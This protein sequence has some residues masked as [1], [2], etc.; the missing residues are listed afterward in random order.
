MNSGP[1]DLLLADDDNDDCRFF[2]EAVEELSLPTHLTMVHDGEQLMKVLT[3]KRAT[4]PH[5]L[6]LDLNLPRKNG[7]EC[8]SEIK[9]NKKLK[10]LFVIIFSTS[11]EKNIVNLLYQNGAQYFIRKPAD[12]SQLK[13]V[14]RQALVM[15][16]KS[17]TANTGLRS[18]ET[19]VLTGNV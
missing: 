18:R 6:F 14:I 9:V 17:L 4:L 3:G 13:K 15:F 19:F 10:H 1:M 2:E 7:L 12:F 8:L 11:A 5:V 16:S